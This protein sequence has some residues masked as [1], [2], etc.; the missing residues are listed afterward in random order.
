MKNLTK[1]NESGISLVEVL[2]TI[3]ISG[4]LFA[5]IGVVITSFVNSYSHSMKIRK[6]T[7][8]VEKVESY[9]STCVE[10]LNANGYSLEIKEENN[11]LTLFYNDSTDDKDL[12]KY[13]QDDQT[14]IRT[15]GSSTLQ[16]NY[17]QD[18]DISILDDSGIVLTITTVENTTI[19]TYYKVLN[20]VK[21]TEI[22]N[23]ENRS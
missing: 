15:L 20:I 21:D 3:A 9:V 17:L 18:I 2:V 4:I 13:S 11:T 8:E 23:E 7:N 6:M 19:T 10:F 14:I 22:V 16:L 1:N 5:L 12:M